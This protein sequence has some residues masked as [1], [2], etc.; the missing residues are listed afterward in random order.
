MNGDGYAD[1]IVGARPLRR[2]RDRRGRGVRLPRQRGG[3]RRTASPPR[4]L[5]AARVRTRRAREL[6]RSV[7][8]AGDVNGD[9]Y[10]DVIVGALALRRRRRPTRARRS[11]STA[12]RSGIA[13]RRSP[14]TAACAARVEPGLG[15]ASARAS[16]R[17]GDVNGD[18]YGD[19]IVGAPLYDAGQTDEGAAFVFL[20]SACGHRRRRHPPRAARAAR[21]EPGRR[22][23]R[24]ERRGGR[25]RERRRL[26]RR[27]R[28][29]PGL[30]R[31]PDRRGRGLRVPRQ[32]GGHRRR[33]PR[34]PRRAA[35]VEPGAARISAAA[36]RRPAT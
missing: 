22:S 29:A 23:L 14:A 3:H 21:V 9:G 27:D 4:A 32:R 19:V 1:V 25:R 17:A 5:R 16:R 28:R 26:R 2:G 30:R 11:C 7:A 6:G 18:G 31:R 10:A 12:R 33:R 34:R 8:G 15:A 36:S 20:G 24:R 13:R 35:R